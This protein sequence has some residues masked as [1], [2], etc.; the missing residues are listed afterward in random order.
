MVVQAA[1]ASAAEVRVRVCVR[2]ARQVGVEMTK[3][4]T[5]GLARG[6]ASSRKRWPRPQVNKKFSARRHPDIL[7]RHG[8][9][10]SLRRP[11]PLVGTDL[12]GPSFL[13]PAAVATFTKRRCVAPAKQRERIQACGG[14]GG[15][16]LAIRWPTVWWRR[17]GGDGP[18][19]VGR[20]TWRRRR[21]PWV[22][23]TE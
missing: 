12:L 21:V 13:P 10:C 2:V 20:V 18:G 6:S 9:W 7:A 11:T 23:Q 22:K 16:E 14:C 17:N 5:C 4:V 19:V 3:W 8:L 1:V 15:G